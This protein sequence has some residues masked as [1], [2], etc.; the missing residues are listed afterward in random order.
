MKPINV[1]RRPLLNSE[2]VELV[3]EIPRLIEPAVKARFRQKKTGIQLKPGWVLPVIIVGACV[4]F[5][6]TLVGGLF[7]RLR[8]RLGD[9]IARLGR[10]FVESIR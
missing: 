7:V 4:A 5:P 9:D 6:A 3:N 1:P 8:H 2:A 10:R